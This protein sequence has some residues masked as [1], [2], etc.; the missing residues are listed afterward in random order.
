MSLEDSVAELLASPDYQQVFYNNVANRLIAEHTF[1]LKGDYLSKGHCPECGHNTLWTK[2]DKPVFIGCN[3]EDCDFKSSITEFLPDIFDNFNQQFPQTD[4]DSHATANAFFTIQK[5]IPLAKVKGWYEQGYFSREH[6]DKSTATVR[7]FLNEERDLWWEHLIE[8]VTLKND[9]SVT[10]RTDNFSPDSL[11][12]LWWTPAG[13]TFK[14]HDRVY[15]CSGILNAITLIVHGFKAIGLLSNKFPESQLESF[16]GKKINW[17]WALNSDAAGRRATRDFVKKLKSKGESSSAIFFSE[18]KKSPQ[19]HEIPVDWTSLDRIEELR[20]TVRTNT[21]TEKSELIRLEKRYP[22]SFRQ[23]AYYAHLGRLELADSY[24][25]KAFLIWAQRLEVMNNSVNVSSFFC[26]GFNRFSYSVEIEKSVFDRKLAEIGGASKEDSKEANYLID[27][28]DD[29]HLSAFISAAEIKPIATFE[30]DFLHFLQP[31]NG[32]PGQYIFKL[33]LSNHAPSELLS[34]SDLTKA[35][36]FK[37]SCQ[38]ANVGANWMGSNGALD[39][40]YNHWTRHNPPRVRSINYVGYCASIDATIL[41]TCAIHRGKLIKANEDG[42]FKIGKHSIQSTTRLK[43]PFNVS[44]VFKS[45]WYWDFKKVYGI[46][47]VAVLA[48][49]TL[50][51]FTQ[52][53]DKKYKGVPYFSLVGESG[54]GKTYLINFLWKLLGQEGNSMAFNPAPPTTERGYVNWMLSFS[55]LPVTWNEVQN[56]ATLENAREIKKGQFDM[57]RIKPLYDQERLAAKS[58]G[59]NMTNNVIGDTFK[60]S[61][62]I[63]QNPDIQGIPEAV[64]TRIVSKRYNRNRKGYRVENETIARN[65]YNR[66]IEDCSGYLFKALSKTTEILACF[67]KKL[68]EAMAAFEDELLDYSHGMEMRIKIKHP[69]IREGHAKILAIAQCLPLIIPE[70]TEDDLMAVQG[71]LLRLAVERQTAIDEDNH[72][73]D[74]FWAFFDER[75]RKVEQFGSSEQITRDLCNHAPEKEL[76]TM[77]AVHLPSLNRNDDLRKAGLDINDL[78]R[79]FSTSKKREYVGY[80]TV[81]STIANVDGKPQILKCYV[82]KKPKKKSS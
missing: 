48:W 47:G 79:L 19:W 70:M 50:T 31:D 77:I 9:D 13:Q 5:G 3:E 16:L 61:L 21:A 39:W 46:E 66:P 64:I 69:R 18:D 78:F 49:W 44:T 23:F 67:D 14:A 40:F 17:I 8:P 15:L 71:E 51:L 20:D 1:K 80:K 75:D 11:K 65:L 42:F 36:A 35:D 6:A 56:E 72:I 63:T 53:I 52:Q 68:P 59:G 58:F 38:N 22:F 45:D 12:V 30:I 62:M 7:F 73:I 60:A 34:V 4:D 26:F 2:A 74:A 55:N 81:R 28:T 27:I 82:F 37:K 10:V 29:N 43:T 57:G 24:H 41:D 54:S 33:L 25:L 32:L 76:E